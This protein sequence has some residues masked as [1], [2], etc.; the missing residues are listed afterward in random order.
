LTR[1]DTWPSD[2]NL[3]AFDRRF[4]RICCRRFGSLVNDRGSVLSISI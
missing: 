4:L 1:I 3:N 2:V